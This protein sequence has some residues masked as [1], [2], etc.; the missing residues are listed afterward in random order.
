[1][2]LNFVY[3]EVLSKNSFLY[4]LIVDYKLLALAVIGKHKH[5][6]LYAYYRVSYLT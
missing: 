3:G 4:V 5:N 2:L 6:I 1:M